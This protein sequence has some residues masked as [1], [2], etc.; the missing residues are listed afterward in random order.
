[1]AFWDAKPW[2]KEGVMQRSGHRLWLV[3]NEDRTY[4]P[5]QAFVERS[6]GLLGGQL[7]VR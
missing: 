6:V 2:Q 7:G 1:M 5:H 4:L 3:K